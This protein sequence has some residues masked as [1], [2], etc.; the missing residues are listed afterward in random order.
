MKINKFF[1]VV[2]IVFSVIVFGCS[3]KIDSLNSSDPFD[4][5]NLSETTLDTIST[6]ELVKICLDSP[7]WGVRYAFNDI[8]TGMAV[9]LDSFNGFHELFDREDA[10]TELL[11]VYDKLDPLAIDAEWTSFEQGMYREEFRKLEMLLS[12]IPMINKFD[13]EGIQK[14]KDVLILKYQ[15][16]KELPEI[17][18]TSMD[19]STTA[20]V[21][22]TILYLKNPD[23]ME[24]YRGE[25]N[26]FRF[27]GW[28]NDIQFLDTIVDLLNA[29]SL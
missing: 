3:E 7:L 6:E 11:K 19:L 25:I 5:Y 21:C 23:I 26:K 9:L 16:K 29:S 22:V 10:A 17:Y 20:Y 12:L 4:E 2:T 27:Y 15:G 1:V 8:G 13:L 14:L 24:E 18:T 28:S